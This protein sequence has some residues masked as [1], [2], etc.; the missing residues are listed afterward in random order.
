MIPELE[1]ER[2]WLR[3]V[4]LEDAEQT[5][6]SVSTLPSPPTSTGPKDNNRIE[7]ERRALMTTANQNADDYGVVSNTSRPTRLATYGGGS[8]L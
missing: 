7:S 1:K 2:M 4:L 5:R 6:N 8:H 3:P